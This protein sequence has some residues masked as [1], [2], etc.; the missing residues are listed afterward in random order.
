MFQVLGVKPAR[1]KIWLFQLLAVVTL[2]CREP[3][4]WVTLE[5]EMLRVA[6]VPF[7]VPFAVRLSQLL[8]N[9]AQ[10]TVGVGERVIVGVAVA[11]EVGVRVGVEVAVGSVP[12]AVDVEEGVKEGVEVGVALLVGVEV[13]KAWLKVI[14]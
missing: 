6:F 11:V 12:V 2:T 13:A 1:L 9:W 8:N 10:T 14:S 4:P 7:H 3:V 5:V